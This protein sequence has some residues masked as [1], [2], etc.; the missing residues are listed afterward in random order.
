MATDNHVEVAL[1][2]LTRH[3]HVARRIGTVITV[4]VMPHV[5]Y[6]NNHIRLFGGTQGFNQRLRFRGRLAELHVGEIFRIADFRR[7]VG[8]QADNGNFQ[9]HAVEDGIGL[10]QAFAGAFLIDI[11][12]QQREFSPLLLLAQHRQRIIKFV[13]ADGHRIITNQVHAAKIG[14]GILQIGFRYASIDVAARQDQRPATFGLHVITQ[15]VH[16]RFLR[17]QTIFA[18][19]VVPEAA[20]M[21]VGVQ[22]RET[23]AAIFFKGL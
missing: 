15:A 7:V 12:G 17:R 13:I 9:S 8:G 1:W 20:M 5:G 3:F 6:G 4:V 19:L 23:V 10:E 16:Q 14:F 21:I 11:G 2:Q 18:P 22:Y